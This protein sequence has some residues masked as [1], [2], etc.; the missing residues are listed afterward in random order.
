MS[1]LVNSSEPAGR[2]CLKMD[3]KVKGNCVNTAFFLKK[4]TNL[5]YYVAENPSE[6][7]VV[8]IGVIPW[9][10]LVVVDLVASAG[11]EKKMNF[12]F[13]LWENGVMSHLVVFPL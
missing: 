11:L 5:V 9:C 3:K 13:N 7:G 6:P 8:A 12:F 10:L 4:N 1:Y 2:S